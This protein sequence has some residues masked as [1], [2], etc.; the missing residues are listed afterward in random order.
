MTYGIDNSSAMIAKARDHYSQYATF[1]TG[2]EVAAT[3][4]GPFNL[5]T[6][7]MT[8]EF[9]A[10][11]EQILPILLS[12]LEQDGL[13]VFATHNPDYVYESTK[14][15]G[16]PYTGFTV[17]QD[18]GT[19][20]FGNTEVPLFIRDT[21]YYQYILKPLDFELLLEEYPPFTS[22]F[23]AKYPVEGPTEYSEY[24]ILGFRKQQA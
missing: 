20:N 7:L 6:S 4:K 11:I 9:I 2:N 17:G 14:S 8:F 10:N 19:L 15:A 13:F 5:I 22:Q 24:L 1:I 16:S 3:Q 21:Q 18:K 12:S 23:L